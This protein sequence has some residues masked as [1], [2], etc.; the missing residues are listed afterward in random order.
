MPQIRLL[1]MLQSV[2]QRIGL[3]QT[4]RKDWK[5]LVGLP[6]GIW[7]RNVFA[8]ESTPSGLGWITQMLRE[9]PGVILQGLEGSV[10]SL[11]VHFRIRTLRVA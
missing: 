3:S 7:M 11:R 2:V 6:I 9:K 8:N 5:S 4:Q 10:Q 1:L